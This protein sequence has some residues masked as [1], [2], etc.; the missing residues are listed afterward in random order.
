MEYSNQDSNKREQVNVNTRGVSFMNSEGSLAQSALLVG[1]WN[2]TISLKLHPTLPADK[3]TDF[4]K[5][6][7]DE[8]IN[9][10]LT[11]EKAVALD[12]I[13][14]RA[15]LALSST[16]D[17][18]KG[19]SVGGDGLVGIGVKHVEDD[20]AV[21]FLGIYKSL[22]PGTRIPKVYN[23][24]Q[25]KETMI[26]DGYSPETGNFN[27]TSDQSELELF[28]KVLEASIAGLSNANQHATRHVDKFFRDKLTN[29]INA[30]GNKLGVDMGANY[31]GGYNR[32]TSSSDVWSNSSSK[33]NEDKS[34][35]AETH[36]SNPD[37]LRDLMN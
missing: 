28:K 32:R 22:D 24:Y 18:F 23:L 7:Y 27:V 3:Q 19:I 12:K 17:F 36:S 26:I 20:K 13:V 4:K 33:S 21:A 31:G 35:Y 34:S 29:N 25:F 2:S 1:Y 11:L 8:V 5:F 6:D 16:E 9:T 30:V 14:G 15:M 10:A 37:E